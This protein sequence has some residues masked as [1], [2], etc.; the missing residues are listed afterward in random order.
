VGRGLFGGSQN[1]KTVGVDMKILNLE[2]IR[3]ADDTGAVEVEIPEW[4]G[5]VY[6]RGL[7]GGE[8]AEIEEQVQKNLSMRNLK[9]DLTLKCTLDADGNR[10]FT[11]A[12]KSLLL[13][14]SSTA[15][16]K[17]FNKVF[18]LSGLTPEGEEIAEGN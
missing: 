10:I 17:I 1:N 11:K 9:I 6:V 8:R 12:E 14:K 15:I 5:A 4:G 3:S 7:T 13:N 16:E 18:E 2:D